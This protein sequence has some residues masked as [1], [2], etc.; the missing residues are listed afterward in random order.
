MG[1][2]PQRVRTRQVIQ[3]QYV[4]KTARAGL[5]TVCLFLVFCPFPCSCFWCFF[6]LRTHHSVVAFLAL[7]VFS[8]WILAASRGFD[9]PTSCSYTCITC[10]LY[11]LHF[12]TVLVSLYFL[13]RIALVLFNCTCIAGL[14]TCRYTKGDFCDFCDLS[15]MP[16]GWNFPTASHA[17][18]H[19]RTLSSCLSYHHL[20]LPR[21]Q[22]SL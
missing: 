21:H 13:I 20:S 16:D 3:S 17:Y 5:F 6:S 2:L 1:D 14:F 22:M 12:S 9:A 11:L 10:L 8:R 19:F 18:N 4:C 7:L 15:E